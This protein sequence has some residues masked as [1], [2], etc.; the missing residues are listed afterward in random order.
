[1]AR[2]AEDVL[3]ID[4]RDERVF[5]EHRAVGLPQPCG[6]ARL[7]ALVKQPADIA[8][9]RHAEHHVRNVDL[10]TKPEKRLLAFL[11]AGILCRRRVGVVRIAVVRQAVIRVA[12][13]RG[14][15]VSFFV[16]QLILVFWRVDL[17]RASCRLIILVQLH[18]RTCAERKSQ[19][20]RQQ[21]CDRS[22]VCRSH[23]CS[24]QNFPLRPEPP[25]PL[26]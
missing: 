23:N 17:T 14:I 6:E 16:C 12:V 20:Q 15:F 3:R 8:Q 10:V 18:P 9:I 22:S 11:G 13:C 24:F 5:A 25:P 4:L 2:A 19:H 21:Q 26:S 7:E 1:M